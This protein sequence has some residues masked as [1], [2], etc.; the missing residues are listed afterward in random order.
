MASVLKGSPADNAGI[1]TGDTI[2]AI[3]NLKGNQINAKRLFDIFWEQPCGTVVHLS[4]VR[5]GATRDL[6]ITLRDLL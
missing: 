6:Y 5:L 4:I 3:N 2:L 1:Q